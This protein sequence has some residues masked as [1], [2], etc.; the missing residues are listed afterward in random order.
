MKW[1]VVAA[2]ELELRA[3][4]RFHPRLVDT[5]ICGAGKT[6]AAVATTATLARM[7]D[8]SQVGVLNVGTAGGLHATGPA[9]VRPS[10]A[11]AWDLDAAA[12]VALGIPVTD[13]LALAGGDGSV[14]A[15]GDTFV[16]DPALRTALAAHACVV[17]MECYAIAAA[18]DAFGVPLHAIKWVSD[19]AD[20]NARGVWNDAAE[21]GSQLLGEAVRQVLDGAAADLTAAASRY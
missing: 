6:A 18:C 3:V 8:T 11:W 16:E 15:S 7:A 17:D 19:R 1:L 20:E 5:L 4:P 12:L 13:R 21:H 14:V 10:S 2:T 9:L